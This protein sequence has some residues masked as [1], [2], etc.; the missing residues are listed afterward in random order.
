MQ[1]IILIG[2]H[3]KVK[4]ITITSYS[5]VTGVSEIALSKLAPMVSPP[6]NHHLLF[7]S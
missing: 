1:F 7:A 6:I 5:E 4:G 2:M 3:L